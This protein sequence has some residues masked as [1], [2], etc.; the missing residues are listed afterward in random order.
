MALPKINTVTYELTLPSTDEKLKY[1]P[2]IVKEQKALMIAQESDDEK[3][4][5]MHLQIL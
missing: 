3:E 1:R 4:I 5:E 2:W